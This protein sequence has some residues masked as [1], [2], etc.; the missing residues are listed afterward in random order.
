[1]MITVMYLVIYNASHNLFAA[2][3]AETE[4]RGAQKCFTAALTHSSE[5]ILV[6]L[7]LSI[8]QTEHY[9]KVARY[10]TVLKKN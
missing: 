2:L 10:A 7:S 8:S 3:L 5:Y 1:M 9:S 4:K 6:A